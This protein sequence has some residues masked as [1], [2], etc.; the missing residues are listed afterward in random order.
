MNYLKQLEFFESIEDLNEKNESFFSDNGIKEEEIYLS[1]RR[2][3]ANARIYSILKTLPRREAKV[4]KLRYG[5]Y[6]EKIK[7]LSEIGKIMNV[8]RER[9]RQ[10]EC[11]AMAKIR[12][13]SRKSKLEEFKD[14]IT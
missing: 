7:T 8:T 10:I 14:M 4:I 13:S 5:F 1:I 6:E 11:K 3:E 9:I 2:E 12:H